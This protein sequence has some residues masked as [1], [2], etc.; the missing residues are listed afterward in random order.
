MAFW[1]VRVMFEIAIVFGAVI[2][3]AVLWIRPWFDDH[4]HPYD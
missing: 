2:F 3:A 4:Y 1:G